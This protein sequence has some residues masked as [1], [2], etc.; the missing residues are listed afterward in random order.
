MTGGE[1]SGEP[2]A[3][4]TPVGDEDEPNW[5]FWTFVVT[6]LAWLCDVITKR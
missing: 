3:G 5:D 4:E 1:P 2:E 6:L